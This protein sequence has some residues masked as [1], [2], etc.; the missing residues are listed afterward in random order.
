MAFKMNGWSAFT[1]NGDDGKKKTDPTSDDYFP[2]ENETWENWNKRTQDNWQLS[3][4]D[5][6]FAKKKNMYY[7][8]SKGYFVTPTPIIN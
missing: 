3:N 2:K 6:N 8:D 5:K 7:D 1:K 4:N